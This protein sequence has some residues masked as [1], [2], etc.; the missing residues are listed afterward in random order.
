[1]MM[2]MLDDDVFGFWI[3]EK[4]SVLTDSLPLSVSITMIYSPHRL[5]ASYNQ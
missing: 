1:M 5:T 4:K 3:L 2:M